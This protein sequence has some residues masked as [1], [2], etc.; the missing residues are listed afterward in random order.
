MPSGYPAAIDNFNNPTAADNLS[1]ATV[2]HNT[3]HTNVNDAVKAIETE[4]GLLPKNSSASVRARLDA[5]DVSLAGKALAADE[6]AVNGIAQLDAGGMLA[7]N[8]D[9]G[10]ITAG[11]VAIARLPNFSGAKVLGT[12]GGGAAI[13]IDAVPSIDAGKT[14]SGAFALARI[15]GLPGSQI[16]SGTIAAAR[17]PS[18]V[19]SNA[20]A[21]VV[22]DLAARD[23]ILLVDRVD[24]MIVVQRDKMILWVWRADNSTWAEADGIQDAVL[25]ATATTLLSAA[26]S[27][28]TALAFNAV[29]GGT[30]AVDVT[31]FA[32]NPS[33]STPGMKYGFGWTGTGTIHMGVQ[34]P[35]V[36]VVSPNTFGAGQWGAGLND[37]VSP[38][39]PVSPTQCGIPSGSPVV[40]RVYAT[41][42]CTAAGVVTL[43][44]AQ[45]VSDA[46]F[47]SQLLIGTRLQA[48]RIV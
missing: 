9:A 30:Y 7:Q 16:T 46:S 4:L 18:S 39:Q 31:A 37:A 23:A 13:P 15:P 29:A 27:N 44:F 25:G 17:L 28:V 45:A 22:A 21:Q 40:H 48:E 34:G 1:T 43:Q 8:V 32:N 14:T 20:N 36:S 6:G 11:T 2:L 47:A 3:Q 19:T 24:G 41:Y 42:I 26:W 33:S 10:K 38:I 12:A 5:I 35:A